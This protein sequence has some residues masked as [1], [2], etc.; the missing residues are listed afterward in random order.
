VEERRGTRSFG[1]DIIG[2]DETWWEE[3]WDWSAVMEGYKLFRREAG[4]VR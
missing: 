1:C 2:I 3:S 4:Q